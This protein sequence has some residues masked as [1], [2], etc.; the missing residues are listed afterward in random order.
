MFATF[1]PSPSQEEGRGAVFDGRQAI[2]G[3]QTDRMLRRPSPNDSIL[4]HVFSFACTIPRNY[5]FWF[6]P[7]PR[8]T[9][10]ISGES[11]SAILLRFREALLSSKL[12]AAGQLAVELHCSGFFPMAFGI[13]VDIIGS[14]IHI[15]SPGIA[16]YVASRHRK[17]AKQL[18]LPAHEC[19][20]LDYP[21]DPEDEEAFFTRPEVTAYRSTLNCQAVRNFVI[22]LV[23][24]ICLSHQKQIAM[25]I[26]QDKDVCPEYVAAAATS[27]KV[28]GTNVLSVAR[29]N[30]V[31]VSLQIMERL[32]F[33]KEPKV[34]DFVFWIVWTSKL[35]AR[36][37]RKGEKL[38]C[39]TLS[40][41]DVA[42]TES[43]HW[44]WYVWRIIF[45]RVGAYPQYKKTQI[46]DI[47]YLYRLNFQKANALIKLPLMI[48]ATR[49]MVMVG[50]QPGMSS[51][52]NHV[53]LHIQACSNVNVL[54]R[55]MQIKLCRRSWADNDDD[56]T[57]PPDQEVADADAAAPGENLEVKKP[58][59]AGAGTG[60][61]RGF[62]RG[63]GRG[64]VKIKPMTKTQIR[65]QARE[66]TFFEL[67]QKTAYLNILPKTQPSPSSGFDM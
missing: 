24:I 7:C 27:L 26:I 54:Y 61:G 49:L 34:E 40:I 41:N 6:R 12:E 8:Q 32:L 38:P 5:L 67:Q 30:E 58:V 46:M 45:K 23:S 29:K 14:H 47:F 56:R 28:G 64:V 4:G 55:N 65:D 52:I 53:H 33:H 16:S 11:R 3:R 31:G 2:A 22:E 18:G 60:A 37:K 10:T 39:K 48:M 19:G 20:T 25:P 36:C 35:E 62:G 21:E 66:K 50:D 59:A 57:Q 17:L 1:T 63:A 9:Q 13:I 42:Q 51:I 43:D 44:S 15:H